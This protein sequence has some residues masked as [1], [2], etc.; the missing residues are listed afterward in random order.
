MRAHA[1]HG[2][3]HKRHRIFVHQA[4][5]PLQREL[6]YV[7]VPTGTRWRGKRRESRCTTHCAGS[8]VVGL[9]RPDP[10]TKWSTDRARQ[11]AF[12]IVEQVGT[13]RHAW[14]VRQGL[15]G[16]VL[17]QLR[18]A[19][20]C[21]DRPV[22]IPGRR[23]ADHGYGLGGVS[24]GSLG[25]VGASRPRP[26]DGGHSTDPSGNERS[27]GVRACGG[28]VWAGGFLTWSCLR[29]RRARALSLP[30]TPTRPLGGQVCGRRGTRGYTN[31]RAGHRRRRRGRRSQVLSVGPEVDGLNH[32]S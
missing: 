11:V 10:N 25:G 23:C 6:P 5:L 31:M 29:C 16:H 2:Y 1:D 20:P 27:E 3:L 12:E 8:S 30:G 14:S 19:P 22:P 9:L 24:T 13:P 32:T 4:E 18:L 15:R 28:L 17:C 21:G 26:P 7:A